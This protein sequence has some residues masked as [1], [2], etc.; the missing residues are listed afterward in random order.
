[1]KAFLIILIVIVFVPLGIW[2]LTERADEVSEAQVAQIVEQHVSRN[3]SALTPVKE[4]VGGTYFVTSIT[5]SNGA[6]VVS[7]EDGH[8]AY[9]ADFTYTLKGDDQIVITS[10]VIK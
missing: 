1:M 2:A 10:F 3:I 6:G 5:S 7:Y 4:Q 8:N 9:T